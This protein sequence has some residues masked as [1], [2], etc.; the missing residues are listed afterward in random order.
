LAV[1]KKVAKYNTPEDKNIN[2]FETR[3]MYEERQK[4]YLAN[5]ETNMAWDESDVPDFINAWKNNWSLNEI[6]E[7][8]GADQW[9]ILLLAVDL[10]KQGKIQGNVHIFKPKKKR[11]TKSVDLKMGEMTIRAVVEKNETWLCLKD[12]WKWIG[13][14]EHSYRKV[15]ENWGPDQRA[16]FQLDTPGG[17][18]R[19]IF[20]NMNG[21]SQLFQH[22][23]KHQKEMLGDLKGAVENGLG[24][25]SRGQTKPQTK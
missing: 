22:V 14:P 13:K 24:F 6:A 23:E 11:G 1:V 5:E 20:I 3:Y 2:Y 17:R 16:K 25:Q 15:T 18:Q 9:E 8:L 7:Y 4:I 19:Y 12:I 21:L 10:I